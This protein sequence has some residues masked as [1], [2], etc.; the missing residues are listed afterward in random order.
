VIKMIKNKLSK[1]MWIVSIVGTALLA[2]FILCGGILTPLIFGAP[3][4]F[5]VMIAVSAVLLIF[6]FA[7]KFVKKVVE[8]KTKKSA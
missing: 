3:I 2:L 8:K 1:T 4:W 6:F 5:W 7:T